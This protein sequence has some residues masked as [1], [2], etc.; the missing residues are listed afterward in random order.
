MRLR[1]RLAVPVQMFEPM[2]TAGTNHATLFPTNLHALDGVR[3]RLTRNR[4][5]LC[6]GPGA[7][8]NHATA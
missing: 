1:T 2:P 5:V 4:C 3:Q 8:E 7:G 6:D